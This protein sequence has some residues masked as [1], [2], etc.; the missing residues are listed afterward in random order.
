M[1]QAIKAPAPKD[2]AD[3]LILL[4]VIIT[5]SVYSLMAFF[6]VGLIVR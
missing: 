2:A 6:F 1:Q 5:V 4:G 3:L